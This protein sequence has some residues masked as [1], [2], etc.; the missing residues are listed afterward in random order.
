TGVRFSCHTLRR[1]YCMTLVDAGLDL[2]TVRRMMRHES[3]VT[4]LS[5]YVAADP[6]RMAEATSVAE[7]IFC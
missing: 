1:F 6:R 3:V 2:D 7:G 4:T 5:N